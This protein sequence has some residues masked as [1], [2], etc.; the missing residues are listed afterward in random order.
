[1]KLFHLSL[2]LGLLVHRG[3][4]RVVPGDGEVFVNPPLNAKTQN[5]VI[6]PR[7]EAKLLNRKQSARSTD[8]LS[9]L[10][11]GQG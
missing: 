3:A 11:V 10:T 1:M 8:E 7:E 4:A 5:S 9:Q 6:C 2:A